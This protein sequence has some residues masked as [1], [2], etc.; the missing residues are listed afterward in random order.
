MVC[1]NF[2]SHEYTDD[3]IMELY[4]E[5]WWN[6]EKFLHCI[7]NPGQEGLR[8]ASRWWRCDYP[9]RIICLYLEILCLTICALI[10]IFCRTRL[11]WK[12]NTEQIPW[13]FQHQA[14]DVKY[15]YE[16]RTQSTLTSCDNLGE[17]VYNNI[18]MK[19]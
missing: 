11:K 3:I 10:I 6:G 4:D 12:I 5:F 14:I 1:L 16:L 7:E 17:V 13:S 19:G 15:K 2:F 18:Y 9:I 8:G